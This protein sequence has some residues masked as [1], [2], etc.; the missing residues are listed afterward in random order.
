VTFDTDRSSA[1]MWIVGFSA[2]P[3]AAVGFA[4]TI[5]SLFMS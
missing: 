3:S 4:G 2:G 1:A 5:T